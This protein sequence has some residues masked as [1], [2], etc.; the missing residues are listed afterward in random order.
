MLDRA[1]PGGFKLGFLIWLSV[2]V[3]AP[4]GAQDLMTRTIGHGIASDVSQ[5]AERLLLTDWKTGKIML[6]HVQSG[7]LETLTPNG[8]PDYGMFAHFSPD[9]DR[10]AYSWRAQMGHFDLRLLALDG[11]KPTVLVPAQDE[12]YF[13][14]DWSPNGKKILV[15]TS[16]ALA[17]VAVEDGSIEEIVQTPKPLFGA[18]ARFSPNGELVAYDLATPL[19]TNPPD[20]QIYSLKDRRELDG[21]LHPAS[22]SLIGWS[23][24]GKWILFD[25]D[26]GGSAALW[27]SPISETGAGK[28][29]RVPVSLGQGKRWAVGVTA[30]GAP[31]Y[32]T[33]TWRAD[34]YLANYDFGNNS[35]G[36]TVEAA[37][38]VDYASG[39]AWSPDGRRLAY[40]RHPK[41]LVIRSYPEGTEKTIDVGL[42]RFH[43]RMPHWIG[44]ET[45]LL[46]AR[47]NGSNAGLVTIDLL[48]GKV[49]PIVENDGQGAVEWETS[50]PSGLAY[51]LRFQVAGDGELVEKDVETGEE[52]GILRFPAVEPTRRSIRH[53][54]LS[55]DGQRLAC[56]QRTDADGAGIADS[57][58][59]VDLANGNHRILLTAKLSEVLYAPAWTP[60]G[61][62]LLFGRG[63]SPQQ[64]ARLEI[65]RVAVGSGDAS[66]VAGASFPGKTMNGLSVHPNGERIA[67][68]L[69]RIKGEGSYTWAEVFDEIRIVEGVRE[70]LADQ[71]R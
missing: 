29:R 58:S 7:A 63:E 3:W 66:V 17:L 9:G 20:I 48:T 33:S 36:E 70:W 43:D 4:L 23:P 1:I 59:L 56:V 15:R 61:R 18:T 54:A 65:W 21:V 35:L 39:A 53:L 50:S 5:D 60:D 52:R 31:V 25:S 51:F 8:Y 49:V 13:V 28:P 62:F 16:R 11:S 71:A 37:T 44:E 42:R 12:S 41:L 32:S 24:D 6:R 45:I 68:T 26:R 22:D 64:D 19:I 14:R 55:A 34:L 57:I 67:F 27:T 69:G 30:E 38:D 10:V 40:A 47:P 2:P 46:G